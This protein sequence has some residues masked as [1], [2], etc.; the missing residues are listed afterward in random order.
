MAAVI[1]GLLVLA[2]F[3]VFNALDRADRTLRVR[4][5]QTSELARLHTIMRRT[6]VNLAMS[7]K[8][9]P[10]SRPGGTSNATSSSELASTPG[11][12]RTNPTRTGDTS[13]RNA[14]GS[15][16]GAEEG[17]T[18]NS[19]ESSGSPPAPMTPPEP[20]RV[21]LA[22]DRRVSQSPMMLL[23]TGAAAPAGASTPSSWKP[24]RLEVVLS[25]PPVPLPR[26]GDSG[27]F[28]E[29]ASGRDDLTEEE[30]SGSKLF[31]GIYELKPVSPGSRGPSGE[32]PRG[33]LTW[34]LWWRPMP[35]GATFSDD[36]AGAVREY[37]LSQ[38]VLIAS[39][40]TYLRWQ[41]Y[42]DRVR[43]TEFATA[44]V[45][46]L[47]AYVEM[48]VQ[49]ASG[50]WANWLFEVDF[51]MSNEDSEEG[52]DSSGSGPKTGVRAITTPNKGAGGTKPPGSNPKDGKR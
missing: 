27:A 37:D 15:G 1:G 49:T 41:F 32:P 45:K 47:P 36:P 5:E 13:G 40:L 17:S 12:G 18:P 3:G 20:P 24:Q 16:P 28:P 50:L 34:S 46:G 19:S 44:Y 51:L 35:P 29:S 21:I 7:V 33:F 38:P 42:D 25:R 48:E 2:A 6:F 9:P 31:R 8:S 26:G 39:D 22:E 10:P 30:V 23:T 4:F 52:S 14:G 11:S 43:K